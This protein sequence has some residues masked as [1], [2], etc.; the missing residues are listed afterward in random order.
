[1]NINQLIQTSLRLLLILS[2]STLTACDAQ[3]SAKPSRMT[4]GSLVGINYTGEGIQRFTVDEAGGG[5]V[6]R[7]GTSGDICCAMYPKKWTPELRV[8]VKWKR[9]DCEGRRQLC[10]LEAA[11]AGTTPMKFLEKTILMEKYTELGEV[12]VTFLP[13]DEV[14]VYVFRGQV[15]GPEFPLGDPHDPDENKRAN[16]PVENSKPYDPILNRG[17]R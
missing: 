15:G 3:E 14:R 16:P 12:Y 2:L 10:T 5:G 17:N 9:T 4:G 1:M 6:S 7:Y 8:T 11:R 13:N